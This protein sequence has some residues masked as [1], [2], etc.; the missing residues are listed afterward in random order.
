MI[1]TM[2]VW[3]FSQPLVPLFYLLPGVVIDIGYRRAPFLRQSLLWLGV[4]AAIAHAS[5][6]MARYFIGSWT[7]LQF[8]SLLGGLAFPLS[9]HLMFG[10]AGGLAGAAAWRLMHKRR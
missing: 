6:P 4:I 2:P 3:G 8:G 7:D 1:S 10:F 9:T 5:K